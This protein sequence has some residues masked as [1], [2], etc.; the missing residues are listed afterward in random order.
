MY[1][2]YIKKMTLQWTN[3]TGKFNPVKRY[4]DMVSVYGEPKILDSAPGGRAI[5]TKEQLTKTCFDELV[6]RDESIAHK[7]PAPHKDFLYA[8]IT[9]EVS[10]KRLP[11]V[12]S[13]SKSIYYDKLKKQITARCHFMGAN[14]STLLLAVKLAKRKGNMNKAKKAEEYKKSIMSTVPDSPSYDPMAY[15]KMEKK[16]CKLVKK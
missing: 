15:K 4:A 6:L 1:N 14:V 10:D 3:K 16:L 13:L 8:T 12:L 5:W 11:D 7:E 2:I 9:Y